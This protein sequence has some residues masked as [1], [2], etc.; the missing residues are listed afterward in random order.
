MDITLA[1]Q[2]NEEISDEDR[3]VVRRV[4]FGIIDGLGEHNKKQWRQF[5]NGI[6]SLEPGEMA[7]VKTMRPRLGPFHRRHFK[8]EQTVFEAQERFE[9]FDQYLYWIKVGSGW[10]R[11]AAGPKG[12]VVPI[13]RSVSYAEADEDEFRKFHQQVIA[14]LRGPHAAEYLWPHL[15]AGKA[16][17]MMNSILKG[18]NE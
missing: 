7:L 18:F 5:V 4:L 10:V 2:N 9:L 1:R 12:G 8:I 3:L 13:P 14:F 11:W 6:M 16:A 15:A 17:E